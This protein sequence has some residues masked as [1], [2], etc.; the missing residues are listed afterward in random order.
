MNSGHSKIIKPAVLCILDGFGIAPPSKANAISLAKMPVF[1][2]LWQRYPH[3]ELQASGRFVGLPSKQAGNSEAGHMNIG[4]G[5]VVTQDSTRITASI[6]DGTFFKNPAFLGAIKHVKRNNSQVHLMGLLCNDQSAHA[7]PRHLQALLKFLRERGVKKIFLHLFTDG[8]DS[9]PYLAIK[10]LRR[11]K[12]S[13]K[14]GEI[15]ASVM[16]RFYAMD[17]K[18][19]WDRT[20]KA[21]NA[22]VL[23]E[24]YR[25]DNSEDAILHAYGRQETDEFIPPSVVYYQGR[26]GGTIKDSDALFFFNLRS[27]RARQLAKPF[28][29]KDFEKRGGFRRRKTLKNLF[30]VALADFGPD[31][32]SIITAYPSIDLLGTLPMALKSYRQLYL[33]EEEKYA[34]VTYFFNGGYADPVAGEERLKIPSIS[35]AHYDRQPAMSARPITSHLLKALKNQQ[36]DF[37]AVNFANPDMLGHTGNIPAT[38][39]G[40]EVVDECLGK[41][42]QAVKA[43]GGNLAVTSDHGN[44]DQMLDLKTGEI[45]TEHSKN[46]VPFILAS[47]NWRKKRLNRGCLGDIAPTI[48]EILEVKKLPEMRG[49]SLIK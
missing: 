45:I 27:D 41:I 24:G 48:L 46:P 36:Y 16:G 12:S 1:K 40:L 14:N 9:P 4:G 28:V 21:Y 32:D 43:R 37:M 35:A 29:Q 34:H 26:P 7:D 19:A 44:C 22:M 15:V 13:F 31:L 38:V 20:E 2:H 23:G 30:F 6:T 3:T 10:L 25:V 11:L 17:R 33:A 18:K 39:K 42:Y 8:R 49:D 47:D 5:R